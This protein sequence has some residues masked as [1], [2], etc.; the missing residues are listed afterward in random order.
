MTL[1]GGSWGLKGQ[2]QRADCM[3]NPSCA[4]CWLCGLE[5]GLI[6]VYV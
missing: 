2:E 3:V 5:E 1:G 6:D 4:S